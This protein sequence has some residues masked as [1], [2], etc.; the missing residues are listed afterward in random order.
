ME[1]TM[2]FLTATGSVLLVL[3]AAA[4]P[5]TA[6]GPLPSQPVAPVN[7][8]PPSIAGSAADGSTVVCTPGYWLNEPASYVYTWQRNATTTISGPSS[9][10]DYTLT[11]SDVGQMITC[12]V[13]AANA[14]GSSSATSSPITPVTA[15]ANGVPSNESPPAITGRAEEGQTVSCAPGAWL[16]SPTRYSYGWQRDGSSLSGQTGQ[17]YR[18]TSGDVNQV[19]TCKVIATNSSG[20]SP[21]A[22]SPP[23]LP[24]TG[25]SGGGSAGTG[26]SHGTGGSGGRTHGRGRVIRGRLASGPAPR[27][28]AFSLSPRRMPVHGR[29]KRARTSGLTF[30]YSLDRRARLMIV[31]EQRRPGRLVGKRCTAV[32][33]RSKKRARC[34][35]HVVLARLIIANA[36]A[37]PGRLWYSG[38][39]GKGLLARGS[40]WAVAAAHT[41]GGSSKPRAVRFTV[42]QTR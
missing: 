6:T 13:T 42:A 34:T 23:I 7:Y 24:G 26:G 19:I 41:Q 9:S 11:S 30:R 10:G 27:L 25:T 31:I 14:W 16:N 12:T 39:V 3:I 38:R 1:R 40:Y 4:A 36:K 22:V 8:V 18:L 35:R 20:D 2:R 29:G 37:G 21:P 32:T 28:G 17:T 5:A 15:P 33:R